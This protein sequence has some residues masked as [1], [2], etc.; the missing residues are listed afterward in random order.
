MPRKPRRSIS[1]S[2]S[3]SR[4]SRVIPRTAHCATYPTVMQAL[5]AA[6]RCSCGL[7]KRFDPPSSRGSSMSIENRR[8]T[9]S[10]PISKLSISARLR[11]WPCQVVVTCQF[12]MPFAGSRLTPSISANRSSTLTPL[13]TVDSAAFVR[14]LIMVLLLPGLGWDFKVGSLQRGERLLDALALLFGDQAGQH[15]AELRVLGAGMDVL[16]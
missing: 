3:I 5:S 4:L 14:A 2:V 10:P 13:T 11:A 16:P 15:L 9:S 1:P 8:G 7:A 12:V 6:I